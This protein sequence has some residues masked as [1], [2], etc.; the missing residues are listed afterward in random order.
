M[1]LAIKYFRTFLQK[2]FIIDIWQGFKYTAPWDQRME[3]PVGQYD[4]ELKVH[5]IS[6]WEVWQMGRV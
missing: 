6:C 3:V 4:D 1:A 2:D 5:W